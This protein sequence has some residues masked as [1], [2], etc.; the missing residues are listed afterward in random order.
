MSM[1]RRCSGL[2]AGSCASAYNPERWWFSILARFFNVIMEFQ[3]YSSTSR[4]RP[5]W[6]CLLVWTWVVFPVY[7]QMTDSR[8]L[9]PTKRAERLTFDPATNEWSSVSDPIPGTEDGDLDIARQ[10]LAREAYRDARR[11][12]K[13][14]IKTYGPESPRYAEALF[15]EGTAYLEEGDY[16]A[17]QDDYQALLI[18]F[19]G[20][21]YAEPALSGLFRIG[22]QYMAGKRRKAWKGLLRIRDRD[23]G[24]AIMDKLIVDYPD[25]QLAEWA[26]KSKADYYYARGEFELAE[27]EYA[28]FAREYPRSRYHPYA[29]IQSARS[30]LASFPGIKF[31][32]AGLI[33]AQERFLQFRKLY[34]DQGDQ[35]DVPVVLEQIAARRADKTLDIGRFYEKTGQKSAARYYYWQTVNRW[36]ESPAGLEA[37][38]RLAALGELQAVASST[39]T[40]EDSGA[41]DVAEE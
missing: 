27:D 14:W 9:P 12:A 26:Q 2:I 7:A 38:G 35:L 1:A 29:L 41:T 39:D 37:Q 10:L 36:P 6:P 28:I 4:F 19:P 17:A 21:P 18:D 16:R 25:T 40:P 34:P 8:P 13:R 20:S 32:D 22:E 33:E 30:A 23:G 15:I 31:D 11:Q 3:Q 5:W 24:V